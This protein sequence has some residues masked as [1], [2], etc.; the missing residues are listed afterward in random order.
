MLAYI[1]N[2][3]LP[4][5]EARRESSDRAALV[6]MDNFKGQVTEAVMSLLEENNIHVCLLPPNTL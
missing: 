5:V 1:E 3:V 2:I 6:V 4:F